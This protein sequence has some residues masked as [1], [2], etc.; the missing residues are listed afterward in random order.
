MGRGNLLNSFSVHPS[1]FKKPAPK[2]PETA[3]S[4]RNVGSWVRLVKS[5]FGTSY[6]CWMPKKLRVRIEATTEEKTTGANK[7]IEKFPS[8][9]WAAKTDAAMGALYDAPMPEA[10]PQATKRRSR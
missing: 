7:F 1:S 5:Y 8:T 4:K 2:A 6:H 10:A 3:P 9:I